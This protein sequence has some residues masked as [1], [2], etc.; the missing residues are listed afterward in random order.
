MSVLIDIK[1][2]NKYYGDKHIIKNLSFSLK[3][4][5]VLAFL[6]P[7]GAGKTT[8]MKM[9]TG[10]INNDGGSINVAGFDINTNALD[11]KENI[12]YV[13]EGSPLYEDMIVV[14]FLDFCAK[15]RGIKSQDIKKSVKVVLDKLNLHSV[16]DVKIETLSKGFKKRVGIAQAIIHNPLILILDE[17]T[18]GLDPNQK[19]EIRTLIEE[20]KKDKAIIISTHILEEAE[21]ICN[22]VIIL[23]N[24]KIMI[25]STPMELLSNTEDK[26]SIEFMISLNNK[27]KLENLLKE[28]NIS[29]YSF[30]SDNGS[31]I[32][33]EVQDLSNNT[34][35]DITNILDKGNITYKNFT[36]HKIKLD[37]IFQKL[38]NN[39]EV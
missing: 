3:K 29:E 25:D 38:T 6:G 1:N 24:G 11:I 13:P 7:N 22:R 14:D 4:G 39:K 17:P 35:Y 8:T 18:D 15:A 30:Y 31:T 34:F 37:T 36:I 12:G 32:V 27:E 10:F 26:K 16:K 9:L 19:E 33:V 20:I 21:A 5:D 28:N 2:V 23:N